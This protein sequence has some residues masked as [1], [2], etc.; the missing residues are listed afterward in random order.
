MDKHTKP[1]IDSTNAISTCT[2]VKFTLDII[3]ISKSSEFLL[4]GRVPD[5]EP[6]GATIGVENDGMHFHAQG[7]NVFLLELA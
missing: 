6:D 7:R 5:V 3:S 4:T 1:Y 2:N